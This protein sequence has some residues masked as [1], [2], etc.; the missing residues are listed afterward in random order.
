MILR[1]K[2]HE[3]TASLIE[4]E[5][6]NINHYFGPRKPPML[7]VLEVNLSDIFIHMQQVSHARVQIKDFQFF[8]D[9]VTETEC[10]EYNGYCWAINH[11]QDHSMR[12]KNSIAYLPLIQVVVIIIIIIIIIIISQILG[13]KKVKVSVPL[14]T[15]LTLFLLNSVFFLQS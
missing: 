1:L 7:C 3:M 6:V 10:S 5:D 8:K 2:K 15:S 9:I 11:K 12:E 13:P 14:Y 4:P